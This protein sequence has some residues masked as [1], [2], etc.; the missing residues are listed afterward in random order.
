MGGLHDIDCYFSF[1]LFESSHAKVSS[2]NYSNSRKGMYHDHIVSTDQMEF[3]WFK[4]VCGKWTR[5]KTLCCTQW[6]WF[7]V[8]YYV[9]V[10]RSNVLM[11]IFCWKRLTAFSKDEIAMCDAIKSTT[12]DTISFNWQINNIQQPKHIITVSLRT[13]A[14]DSLATEKQKQS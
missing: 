14:L 11:D 6:N 1:M 10:T 3:E 4:R 8:F 2:E 9:M 13:L 5:V 7:T 12:I